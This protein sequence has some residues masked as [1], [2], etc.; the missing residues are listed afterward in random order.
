MT[1][2]MINPNVT[3]EPLLE[4]FFQFL[5]M[6]GIECLHPVIPCESRPRQEPEGTM[7]EASLAESEGTMPEA[8][9]AFLTI[10]HVQASA[11]RFPGP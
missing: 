5:W 11:A 8:P 10:P 9:L 6:M 1:K 7:P 3:Q 4:T 2:Y